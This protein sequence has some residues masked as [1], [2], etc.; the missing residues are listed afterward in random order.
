MDILCR[1]N[2][3][4]QH[5]TH[6]TQHTAHSTQHIIDA[7][8]RDVMKDAP[9]GTVLCL[10]YRLIHYC[11]HP[12]LNTDHLLNCDRESNRLR[13]SVSAM[14]V[15]AVWRLKQCI[16]HV[17][18]SSLWLQLHSNPVDTIQSIFNYSWLSWHRQPQHLKI[19]ERQYCQRRNKSS[20]GLLSTAMKQRSIRK[21]WKMRTWFWRNIQTMAKR[22]PWK[23]SSRIV[24]V[25]KLRL[26]NWWNLV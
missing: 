9:T 13:L 15:R 19:L 1:T 12:L 3:S 5:T 8:W 6:S 18:I 25:K 17:W 16:E 11:Q 23:V 26:M 21:G 14:G 24:L 10:S 7:M 22:W 4:T 20:L 2:D